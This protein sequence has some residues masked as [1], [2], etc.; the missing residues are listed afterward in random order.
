MGLGCQ[1]SGR[2]CPG[3][4]SHRLLCRLKRRA[5]LALKVTLNKGWAD[6][7]TP[8][9]RAQPISRLADQYGPAHDLDADVLSGREVSALLRQ[10]GRSWLKTAKPHTF[11][12]DPEASRG[13]PNGQRFIVLKPQ[14]L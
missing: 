11:G 10:A 9:Q 2:G 4:P 14:A 12:V 13:L 8:S 5:K 3:E 1:F 7:L 6:R